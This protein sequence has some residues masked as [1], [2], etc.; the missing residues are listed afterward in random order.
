MLCYTGKLTA[1][2][3]L[4]G[5]AGMVYI[6]AWPHISCVIVGTLFNL[7]EPQFY[8]LEK[9]ENNSTNHVGLLQE[10]NGNFL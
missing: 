5:Q 8:L 7:S 2:L 10:I 3:G 6:L 4:G 1:Q 9:G